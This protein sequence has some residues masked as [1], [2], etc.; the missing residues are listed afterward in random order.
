M[1]IHE[2]ADNDQLDELS[3]G[4]VGAGLGKG[5]R[6]VG[7]GVKNFA[8]GFGQGLM[9]NVPGKGKNAAPAAAAA[10]KGKPTKPG[11]P[12]AKAKPGA[13]PA[14]KAAQPAAGP[15]M[16]VMKKSIAAFNPKQRVAI[17]QQAAKKA[18]VK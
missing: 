11:A 15:D 4:E 9:G 7:T 10:P 2:F 17:R 18:G 16:D 8:K 6:A 14:A 5:V 3:A 12:A 1:K 13:A